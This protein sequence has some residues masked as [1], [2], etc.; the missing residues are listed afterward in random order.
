MN[1]ARPNETRSVATV[2]LKIKPGA[3]FILNET[4][5]RDA[6]RT[7]ADF[8]PIP[9]A[10]DSVGKPG[11]VAHDHRVGDDREPINLMGPPWEDVEPQAINALIAR[12]STG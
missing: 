9:I 1:F 11:R 6:V 4:T 8:L 2:E 3:S 5:L 7:Y 12:A 10:I